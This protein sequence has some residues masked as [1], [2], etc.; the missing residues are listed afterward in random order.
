MVDKTPNEHNNDIVFK[1]DFNWQLENF[2]QPMFT[3]LI[4]D[5]EDLDLDNL[6]FRKS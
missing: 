5:E 1:E 3:G 2:N 6:I 4:E